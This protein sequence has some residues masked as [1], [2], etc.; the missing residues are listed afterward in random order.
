MLIMTDGHELGHPFLNVR[1]GAGQIL[2][3]V[4]AFYEL[5]RMN[6]ATVPTLGVVIDTFLD[7]FGFSNR[8]VN[9]L[10]QARV[11]ARTVDE[12]AERLRRFSILEVMWLWMFIELPPPRQG[13]HRVRYS[14]F[15]S[16]RPQH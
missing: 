14:D 1:D 9:R 4:P 3:S 11:N 5:E 15:V 7:H 2:G 16:S 10:Y 12:F 8:M 6:L 13:T